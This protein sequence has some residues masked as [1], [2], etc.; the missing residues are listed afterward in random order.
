MREKG[1]KYWKRSLHSAEA[2][3][4]ATWKFL[5]TLLRDGDTS[6]APHPEFSDDY[7]HRYIDDKIN[8]IR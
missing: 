3:T 4:K 5:N 7:R 2:D 6:S 1:R 8:R